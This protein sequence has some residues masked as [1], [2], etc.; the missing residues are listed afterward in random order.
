MP[1]TIG[2][3]IDQ[4][5]VARDGAALLKLGRRRSGSRGRRRGLRDDAAPRRR[6]QLAAGDVPDDPAGQRPLGGDRRRAPPAGA[7]RRGRGRPSPATPSTWAAPTTRSA[8]FTGGVVAYGLVAVILLRISVPLG[9]LVLIGVP[10]VTGALGGLIAPLHRRQAAQR[11]QVGRL[12]TL[13]ADTVTGLRV[14][15][16]IG[17][18]EIFSRRYAE[19]SRR[20]Q[21]EG[22][23]VGAVQSLLDSAQVLLPGIFVVLITWIGARFA[24]EGRISAG[25]LV[26][27]YGYAAFLVA[28][29]STTIEMAD[30]TTRAY[31]AARR[32]IRVLSVQPAVRD[33]L[34]TAVPPPP[35]SVLLD[36]ESGLRIEPGRLTALVSAY[37]EESAALADR[38]GRIGGRRAGCWSKAAPGCGS[39]TCRSPPCRWPRCGAGWWSARPS[40]GCSPASCATSCAARTPV[41]SPTTQ[42]WA[43]VETA[44]AADAIDALPDG[45]DSRVEERGRSLSGGQRQ[46]LALARAL[47]RDAETLVLVEPT[48]AVDAHT[49]ARIGA[50]AARRPGRPVD[51]R[52]H[53]QPADAGARRPGRLPG[54]RAG[55][56]DRHARRAAGHHTGLP[57]GREPRRGVV[58]RTPAAA[59]ARAGRPAAGGD[60]GRGPRRGPPAVRRAPPRDDPGPG[61]ARAGRADRAGRAA[62]PRPAGRGPGRA[63]PHG[64]GAPTG[65]PCSSPPRCSCSR[66]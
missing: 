10:V 9:L 28:P 12:T 48:S 66:C 20:V 41:T 2:A 54:R 40:R 44:S 7:D 3:A 4:G 53:L 60:V 37:P 35:G 45:L 56:G 52:R 62:R 18:E 17:G 30:R 36:P 11:E 31:V 38:L 25:Q 14:L 33:P 39:A 51:R 61:A 64:L 13:G 16:G 34:V 21:A 63:P 19:Q 15:R 65:T 32:I 27:A 55:P 24:I 46:R 49:E 59:R 57:L 23:R 29:L 26:A 8:R 22:V 1:V 43:A 50:A 47:L 58:M 42:I 6:R 5:V